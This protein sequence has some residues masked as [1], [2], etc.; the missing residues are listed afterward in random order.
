MMSTD[1]IKSFI[2]DLGIDLVGVADMTT[3]NGMPLGIS[4]EGASFL[5]EFPRAIVLGAQYGK[6]GKNAKG[7][8]VSFFL[9][10]AALQVLEY[11]E[12]EGTQGLIIH[13]EDEYN[14]ITRQGLLS[15]KVLAKAAG[16]GW[17]GRSLLIVSPEYGPV[18]RWVAV[19]TD[20]DISPDQPLSNECG[21]CSL[22][23][24]KCPQ[25]ALTLVPFEDH[26]ESREAVLN[27]PACKGDNGCKVCIVVCPWF[28]Q[29]IC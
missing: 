11:L 20:L 21:S 6:I 23:V 22:C 19:L 5:D 26:P 10:N 25:D 2:R 1:H 27:V 7:R 28:R 13:T 29:A 3:L 9:E 17:Q 18:H 15:L 14:P 12:E 24:D 8:E 4:A 16:L